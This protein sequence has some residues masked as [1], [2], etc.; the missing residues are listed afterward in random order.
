MP[1]NFQFEFTYPFEPTITLRARSSITGRSRL[2]PVQVDTGADRTVLDL[3]IAVSI[4]LDPGS[5][6]TI[7]LMGLGGGTI[8]GVVMDVE[9]LLLDEEELLI[10]APV[11]FAPLQ[12]IHV[13]NLLGLD[14]LE[15]FDFGLSHH[16]RLG[17][18]GRSSP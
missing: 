7:S 2:A 1:L 13:G 11:A 3:R 4:G 8:E 18:L 14:L 9:L 17:Y 15:H 10:R 6:Q 12:A 5:G 16:Q